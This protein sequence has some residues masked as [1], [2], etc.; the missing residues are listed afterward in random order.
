MFTRHITVCH[1][2]GFQTT[3]RWLLG[4]VMG[5]LTPN[6]WLVVG[7]GNTLTTVCNGQLGNPFGRERNTTAQLR[8]EATALRRIGWNYLRN[9]PVLTKGAAKVATHCSNRKGPGSWKEVVEQLLLNRIHLESAR[10]T[11]Q[12]KI[13]L[14]IMVPSN[15]AESSIVGL[16]NTSSGT[17]GASNSVVIHLLMP[18]PIPKQDTWYK[19]HRWDCCILPDAEEEKKWTWGE[20]TS[21][22]FTKHRNERNNPFLTATSDP[23]IIQWMNDLSLKSFFFHSLTSYEVVNS[24]ILSVPLGMAQTVLHHNGILNLKDVFVY[25]QIPNE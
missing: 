25:H 10:M 13:Q 4:N 6:R 1:V 8:K 15:S 20:S 23:N 19:V 2:N 24:V 17:T 5:V 3:L 14:A 7:E 22:A 12:R 21:P 11:I 16:D 18:H 9:P